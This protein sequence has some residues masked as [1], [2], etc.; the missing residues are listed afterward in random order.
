MTWANARKI[1]DVLLNNFFS[2]LSCAF[3]EKKP[4][5]I[6]WVFC[7]LF[8]VPCVQ[9]ILEN[10]ISRNMYLTIYLHN[11]NLKKY[12]ETSLART[13]YCCQKFTTLYGTIPIL[14]Q[15]RSKKVLTYYRDGLYTTFRRSTTTV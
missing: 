14:R 5:K 11:N 8:H 3:M 15:K 6:S 9:Y 10:T 1:D 7:A 12:L 4:A 2:M 13:Y